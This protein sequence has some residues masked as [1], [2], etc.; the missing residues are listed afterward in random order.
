MRNPYTKYHLED[1]YR[2]FKSNVF[3]SRNLQYQRKIIA[4]FENNRK[5]VDQ[6][7]QALYQ[8]LRDSDINYFK[9]LFKK[10][11]FRIY[12]KNI[13]EETDSSDK[14]IVSNKGEEKRVK[15]NK[16]NFFIYAPIEIFILDS[17]WAS[18][19]ASAY[20][21][22]HQ[23]IPEYVYGNR[24]HRN[25][26]K[27]SGYVYL[28]DRISFK[29][30][31]FYERYFPQYKS[32]KNKAIKKVEDLY[33][34]KSDC[35]ILSLDFASFYYSVSLDFDALYKKLVDCDDD[36]ESFCFL[37]EIM[38]EAYKKY[39]KLISSYYSAVPKNRTIIPIG[40]LSSGLISNIYLDNF[41]EA[42]SKIDGVVHYGR[43]VD[44]T[45]FVIEKKSVSSNRLDKDFVNK[46]IEDK[47]K[48]ILK[49]SDGYFNVAGEER[50]SIKN[51]KVKVIY[52]DSNYPRDII[53]KLKT[54]ELPASEPNL[55]PD[56]SDDFK[57]AVSNIFEGD[58]S[59]KIRETNEIRID[60]KKLLS[61]IQGYLFGRIGKNID[62]EKESNSPELT[63]IKNNF[64]RNVF[65][66]ISPSAIIELKDTWSKLIF[67][68]K[69][70]FGTD[71][72][73]IGKIKSTISNIRFLDNDKKEL[74]ENGYLRIEELVDTYIESLKELLDIAKASAK[75]IIRATSNNTLSNRLRNSNMIDFSLIALPLI[76]YYEISN[77]PGINYF[78]YN[79]EQFKEI[80]TSAFQIDDFKVKYS[81]AFIHFNQY[82]FLQL[83]LK[84]NTIND[85]ETF[86]GLYNSY[87]ETIFNK[88]SEAEA[89]TLMPV[90]KTNARSGSSYNLTTIDTRNT[91]IDFIDK[92]DIYIGLANINMSK[93]EL[94]YIPKRGKNKGKR[95][96]S[97]KLSGNLHF[98]KDL[99][100]LLRENIHLEKEPSPKK[101]SNEEKRV[102]SVGDKFLIF[103][104]TF[105]EYEW[106]PIVEK[107]ARKTR[108]V[109]VTGIKYFTVD[110]RLYN[111]QATIIPYV[112]SENYSST[113]IVLREKNDYAPFEKETAKNSGCYTVDSK[114]PLYLK[115]TLPNGVVFAPFICYELTD[116]YARA[117]FKNSVDFVIACEYNQD[118]KYFS[119]VIE[120]TARELFAFVAQVNSSDYG[121]TRI[122]APYHNNEKTLISISGGL[123][124][125]VHR[126]KINVYN[127]R[128]FLND[129][130]ECDK[131]S[132][133]D[134]LKR[135]TNAAFKKPSARSSTKK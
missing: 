83:F 28:E 71:T 120:S 133:Y 135:G 129:F 36:Y 70:I 56:I 84:R 61:S 46:L 66:S 6:T 2:K 53:D 106:L 108:T 52:F 38:K 128:R 97:L 63:Q 122:V 115:V 25:L 105:L 80:D 114:N 92:S 103:P 134:Q 37:H 32:W 23:M 39:S 88:F 26:F 16:F 94:T 41:D 57:S 44:D 81:P 40:L 132:D 126:G 1:S 20:Y 19:V 72:M 113:I 95:L 69:S 111:Y 45:I 21:K 124:T 73:F 82:E 31:H 76:N 22:H 125:T 8:A 54:A 75:A 33:K 131:K 49:S 48:D 42:V 110:K 96:L 91:A 74:V 12:Q 62:L 58:V 59:L 116:I 14:K 127:L 9:K 4:D 99:V 79:I 51:D 67:F 43:Y 130:E 55:Y 60:S 109:V 29:S 11:G 68:E 24:I 107:Y 121:D 35:Y 5:K 90:I 77:K 102:I 27:E 64:E 78:T 93:H 3:Y 34:N 13:I 117:L 89:D 30:L 100:R 86:T 18:I 101:D 98:K 112:I 123:R 104:E 17:Y 119:N 118:I 50:L 65:S 87:R 7:F 85:Q 15:I 47:F 10:I